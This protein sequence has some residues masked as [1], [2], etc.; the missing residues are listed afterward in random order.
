[1][2]LKLLVSVAKELLTQPW[3][4]AESI[5][6]VLQGFNSWCAYLPDKFDQGRDYVLNLLNT[7]SG[8][9]FELMMVEVLRHKKTLSINLKAYNDGNCTSLVEDMQPDKFASKA[10]Q[11]K[12]QRCINY[13]K[14]KSNC[15]VNGIRKPFKPISVSA[16]REAAARN[17]NSKVILMAQSRD[18]MHNLAKERLRA[19][20]P[21]EDKRT[22]QLQLLELIGV[23]FPP[24]YQHC[25]TCKMLKP[26][27]CRDGDEGHL[28]LAFSVEFRQTTTVQPSCSAEMAYYV[29]LVEDRVK[30]KELISVLKACVARC[31]MHY[32]FNVEPPGLVSK[33][34]AVQQLLISN[35]PLEIVQEIS[36][37]PCREQLKAVEAFWNKSKG[38][39]LEDA[40]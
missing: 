6:E 4:V 14:S 3:I 24:S 29:S 33:N 11:I 10:E 1:M 5:W 28:R 40:L 18:E 34:L 30:A 8:M 19:W 9:A 38:K 17:R 23:V 15:A 13:Q 26:V 12:Q 39:E 25:V 27:V 35:E 37:L 7:C 16:Q 2:P 20:R 22:S 31:L 32:T 21:T 36:L